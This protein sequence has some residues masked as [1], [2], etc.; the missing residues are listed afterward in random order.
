MELQ[1]GALATRPHGPECR[2]HLQLV[3]FH[4]AAVHSICLDCLDL[5]YPK[6]KGEPMRTWAQRTRL[7]SPSARHSPHGGVRSSGLHR[8]VARPR[9]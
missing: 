6:P 8:V 3:L 1:P 2:E 5:H 7:T 9:R 4:P